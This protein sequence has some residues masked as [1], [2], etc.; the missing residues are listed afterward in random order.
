MTHVEEIDIVGPRIAGGVPAPSGTIGNALAC[1]A[2]SAAKILDEGDLAVGR[3][4]QRHEQES[5]ENAAI[6]ASVAEMIQHVNIQTRS[7][8]M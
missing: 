5:S 2:V 4:R 7:V 8:R 1:V 3:R 6:H